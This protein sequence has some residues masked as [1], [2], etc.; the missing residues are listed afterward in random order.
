[1]FLLRDENPESYPSEI[2]VDEAESEELQ[3]DGEAVE[4]PVD[5]SRQ[6]VG[7]QSVAEVEGEQGGAERGPEQAEEQEDALVAPPLVSGEVEEPELRVHRQEQSAVQG[8]VE[9]GEAQLDRRGD[10]RMQGHRDRRGGVGR[11]R[12][13]CDRSF[14]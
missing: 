1:L 2:Q 3:A 8:G 13:G 10:G 6:V 9:D 4:Q 7:L 11:S 14:H 12:V 5:C